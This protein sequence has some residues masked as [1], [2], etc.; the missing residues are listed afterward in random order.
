VELG[1][2]NAEATVDPRRLDRAHR[3]AANA[4]PD[5][6]TS[7][8]DFTVTSALLAALCVIDRD[9]HDG[10]DAATANALQVVRRVVAALA[11]RRTEDLPGKRRHTLE[12]R[13]R[14]RL[15]GLCRDVFG[16][17]W[18]DAKLQRKWL[19]EAVVAAARGIFKEN[20]FDR[21]PE[22]ADALAAAEC[23]DEQVL[24]HCRSQGPHV[25]GC[26]VVDLVLGARVDP[27]PVRKYAAKVQA[28]RETPLPALEPG[29]VWVGVPQAY[30]VIF[31]Y[32]D[33]NRGALEQSPLGE[34][35]SEIFHENELRSL[36]EAGLLR[37]FSF[38]A[39]ER[40]D[41][42][43]GQVYV[44]RPPDSDRIT[45]QSAKRPQRG[46]LRLPT[47]RLRIEAVTSLTIGPEEAEEQGAEVRVP[48]GVYEAGLYVRTDDK[49]HLLVLTPMQTPARSP[50]G[51]AAGPARR[52]A[53]RKGSKG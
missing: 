15:A 13:P 24:A 47:G 17:P 3:A 36:E 18:R 41:P 53:G 37:A 23:K 22:L 42:F 34:L 39:R 30:E 2:A 45:K 38:D 50:A 31:L 25:R 4:L 8:R 27:S 28:E 32:D 16:N 5:E 44:G 19:T 33:G 35:G 46:R 9:R 48:A 7:P 1:E 11:G 49:V 40:E 51:L 26:W 52:R 10:V 43:E 12:A 29:A 6:T 20:A 21:L 14:R